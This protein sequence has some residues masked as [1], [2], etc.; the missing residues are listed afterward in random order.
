[1]KN[2]TFALLSLLSPFWLIAQANDC[3]TLYMGTADA[4]PGDTICLEVKADGMQELL[5]M[6]LSVQWD[7]AALQFYQLSD[8]QLPGLSD[9]HFNTTPA[10]VDNGFLAM[11]WF[12]FSLAGVSMPDGSALFSLC[13]EVLDGA[14]PQQAVSFSGSP[15]PIEFVMAP[16][17][18][19]TAY[20]LING[21]AYTAAGTPPAI[22]AACALAG[23]CQSGQSIDI[24][25]GGG[26]P[27]YTYTWFKGG[28]AVSTDEDLSGSLGGLYELLVADA[29]GQTVSGS[30]SM[31]PDGL[32]YLLGAVIQDATCP[33]AANGSISLQVSGDGP[34]VV[35]EWGH[36]ATGPYVS[37]L[38]PGLY[39][40]EVSNTTNGCA[41]TESFVVGDDGGMASNYTYA[42]SGSP[43]DYTAELS[44]TPQGGVGP[45]T[46]AW[47]TG[48]TE[49][50]LSS[51]TIDGLPGQGAYN[52]T[53]TDASGC[54]Q[55]AD[56]FYLDCASAA[57]FLSA[58][59]YECT[60]FPD[61]STL[62]DVTL[63]IWAGGTPPYQFEWSTGL[64]ETDTLRSVAES[65]ADGAYSVTVTD[66]EGLVYYPDP[67][68]L[69]CGG[70]PADFLVGFNYACEFY[71]D[72]A[73]ASVSALVWA[74][75]VPPYTFEWNTGEID[76]DNQLSQVTV[77]GQG[78][79]SLTI[80]DSEGTSYVPEPVIVDCY[81]GP[82]S[83]AI[84]EGS[85]PAGGSI[86]IP[87]TASGL[88]GLDAL[89]LTASW[90]PDG[91]SLMSVE[92][93]LIADGFGLSGITDGILELD[94]SSGGDPL[95]IS[96]SSVLFT[97][98]FGLEGLAGQSYPVVFDSSTDPLYI[99]LANGNEISDIPV[100][101]GVV[102]I[103]SLPGDGLQ[104][105]AGSATV[106][107]GEAV[108]VPISVEQ[109]EEIVGAQFTVR[110]DAD[111]LQFDSLVYGSLPNLSPFN[112]NLNHTAEGYLSFLWTDPTLAGVSLPDGS[113][114]FSLCFTAGNQ[115]G[116]SPLELSS[117]PTL[118]EFTNSA[119]ELEAV[120]IGQGL[121]NI[122]EPDVWPGD[123]DTDEGV[124]HY[125][126]LNIGLAYGAAG[127]AR[128]DATT[129]W[130]EQYAPGWG[131]ATPASQVDYKHIDT[132]G[133]GL[134]DAA[135]TLAIVQNWGQIAN[136]AN[137]GPP[138]T[139]APNTVLYIQPDTVV[140]GQEAVF[141]IMLGDADNPADD[142]YGLAFTVVYDTA[143][144]E[145]G[146]FATFAG[147]WMG[148]PFTSLLGLS[149]D[150]YN[151]GRID[152]AL[153]RIDG[154]NASGYGAIG[155]LHITIQDVIFMRSADYE[156]LFQIENVRLI[157]RQ[158]VFQVVQTPETAALVEDAISGAGSL[159]GTAEVTVFPVPARHVLYLRSPGA[160]IVSAELLSLDGRSLA[161]YRQPQ[162]I[163]LNGL[164]EGAY[165]L[166]VWTEQGLSIHRILVSW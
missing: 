147:S 61:G 82:P 51:S 143:A 65:L 5:S 94:W 56:T 93:G 9:T 76:F 110:W 109:F 81:G 8:M 73:I 90:D 47:S 71:P 30:F 138:P 52:V 160:A 121:I 16:A 122:L 163:P 89:S 158:E 120:N 26:Q 27:P 58:Y 15:T 100:Q 125:D 7:P 46:F 42:C 48:Q 66:A 68:T 129:A 103:E 23:D 31:V 133:N 159:G 55:V 25:V 22:T 118:I 108:C 146:A 123:T 59:A 96:A 43:G 157:D 131:L 14:G 113:P 70:S 74:G 54:Q 148:E 39:T 78:V 164:S 135:D 19:I 38:A 12:D 144:V 136:I 2:L 50:G 49:T 57:T 41:Y 161:M 156:M 130:E 87:V 124:D 154:Q 112:F 79:Y 62:G 21:G 115:A 88:I 150:R 166:R 1:M 92:P 45:Y 11:A 32:P 153:T 132:D 101:N 98:C 105:T 95:N 17:Q 134:I 10:A 72:T 83:L 126:L 13:F 117:V 140:L 28:Q 128:P 53:I 162:E 4:Q 151:D 77:P 35:Y 99:L 97:L 149:R 24:T 69:E 107:A 67:F 20:S 119:V 152:I 127:P 141:N 116:S 91:L 139:R 102:L 155:Q 29:A 75:G 44:C 86:C 63:V 84:G 111:S 80:T 165:I 60:S 6:Q 106:D 3:F 142:V 85:G 64:V 114:L 40:V 37:N 33:L 137:P 104:L 145:P 18:V 34:D 36:G